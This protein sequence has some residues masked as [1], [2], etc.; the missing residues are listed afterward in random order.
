MADVF[1]SYSQKSVEPARTLAEQLAKLGIEVWWDARLASG[2]RFD[3]VIRDELDEADAAIVVW[4]PESV[5]SRYV[6]MEAGIAYAFEKLVTVR[7]PDLVTTSIPKPFAG[8]HA[9][10]VT[11]V[12]KILAALAAKGVT[13]Q[14]LAK[15]AKYS[16]EEMLA[17]MAKVDGNLPAAVKD[18]LSKCQSDGFKIETK[19][20]II[21]KCA[22]P[23]LGNVNFGTL[24]PDGRFQTNYI[25]YSAEQIGDRGIAGAY[26]D[27]VARLIN[28]ANVNREGNSWTW[29]VEVYGELPKISS[30]LAHSD[31]WLGL[32]TTARARFMERASVRDSTAQQTSV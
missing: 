10:L 14:A 29:R 3:D 5:N 27:G 8:F 12:D 6:R 17:A 7:T 9:D 23:K 24:F 19:R 25:S 1:I 21:I 15:R 4:S 16:M 22:V 26:L 28:G 13:P 30:I 11:D 18:F 2:Q 31:D 32:M 20:S